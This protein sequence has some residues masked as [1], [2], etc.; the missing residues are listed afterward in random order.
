MSTENISLSAKDLQ[1]LI[2]TA[3][4]E[5]VKAAKEPSVI[6]QR[7]LDAEQKELEAKNEERKSNAAQQLEII[8]NKRMTQSICSHQHRDG[9]SHC[10]YIMEKSGPGYIL[11]QKNQCKIRPGVK[12]EKNYNGT[13]IYDT[14]LFNKL[15]QSLPSNEMFQ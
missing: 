2:A 6:E 14:A 15:F 3:V 10:V 13:D 12:P 1:M 4:S 5:A 9:N 8:A 7:Q 11:C